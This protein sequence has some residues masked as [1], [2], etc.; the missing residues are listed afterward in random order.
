MPFPGR[1]GHGGPPGPA[2]PPETQAR[3]DRVIQ[4]E[5]LGPVMRPPPMALLG[6]AGQDVLFRGPNGQT[7]LVREGGELGG[8]HIVRI[9][10]NRVLVREGTELKELTIFGGIGGES[11]MPKGKGSHS[12]NHVPHSTRASLQSGA[13][14][15]SPPTVTRLPTLALLSALT[16][17]WVG[18]GPG[19][20]SPE[21]AGTAEDTNAP[22]AATATNLPASGTNAPPPGATNVVT[23][24]PGAANLAGF[25]PAWSRPASPSR[26]ARSHPPTPP[27]AS[28]SLSRAPGST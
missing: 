23:P 18:C 12:V 17:C 8:V 21:A 24:L 26:P 5:L 16:V 10:T 9:G 3:L 22:V 13:R 19:P 7:G 27:R 11:L 25:P 28:R 6:I 15:S 2:L 14:V 1:P 20:T 4:S